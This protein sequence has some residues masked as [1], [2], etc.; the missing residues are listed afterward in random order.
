MQDIPHSFFRPGPYAVT[1]FAVPFRGHLLMG[2]R[3]TPPDI[4][5]TAL[6]LHGGGSSS[7]ARFQALRALLY[8]RHIETLAFDFIGH[9]RTGSA[10]LGTTLD[11]R[12]QQVLAATQYLH[13]N[14]SALT[15]IGF[16]T[17]AYVAIIARAL[18]G[19]SH[20]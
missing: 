11:E 14:P 7:V 1:D 3:W 15:L 18:L 16:S 12:V 17:G 9:G 2:D 6:L 13:L 20:L 8:Q 10:Q 4:A 5:G 19:V